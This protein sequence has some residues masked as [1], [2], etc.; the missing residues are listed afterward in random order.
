[1]NSDGT[2]Q[3]RLTFDLQN[4]LTPSFSPD[5]TKIAFTSLR[6]GN[7]EVYTMNLDGSGILQVTNNPASDGN[8]SWGRR[9]GVN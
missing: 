5:G 4:N 7:A 2:N 1:M 9:V 3:Q 6:S 8:P